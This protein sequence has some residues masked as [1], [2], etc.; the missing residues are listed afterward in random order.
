M[1]S[2]SNLRL[3][4]EDSFLN[5]GVAIK[6]NRRQQTF[7]QPI[8]SYEK[9][10]DEV[11][12]RLFSSPQQNLSDEYFK[13]ELFSFYGEMDEEDEKFN[14]IFQNY[15]EERLELLQE[16]NQQFEQLEVQP[17]QFLW[18]NSSGQCVPIDPFLLPRKR[19]V[20]PQNQS[21]Y[22]AGSRK[23]SEL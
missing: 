21:Q 3:C 12:S 6:C 10:A 19:Q 14:Q 9:Y 11:S 13:Q 8:F 15:K 16:S 7:S 23:E 4:S 22:K 5:S 18:E 2:S 1:A 20:K 17:K